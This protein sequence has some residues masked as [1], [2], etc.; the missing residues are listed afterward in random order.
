MTTSVLIVED[1]FLIAMEMEA[2]VTEL[3]YHCAG[4]ADDM[5]SAMEKASDTIDVA[6]VD[7]NLMD[8]PTGPLIAAKLATEFDIEVVFV[9]AN[10]TQLGDGVPGAIGALEKPVDLKIL[11][12]V[13][14]YVL[15]LRKGE[16]ANPPECLHLF[17][18]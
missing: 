1:E 14:D 2:V 11:Q 15:S 3:G 8:G 13:L 4:I 10:P 18:D 16:R 9:T 17:G 5:R 12:Q 6:L 7:V